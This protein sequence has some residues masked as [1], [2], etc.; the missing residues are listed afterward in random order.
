[1]ALNLV[2]GT[3]LLPLR[4][5]QHFGGSE[6]AWG[7]LYKESRCCFGISSRNDCFLSAFVETSAGRK[8]P[9][10]WLYKES[11]C[12]FGI[13]S[14]NW[15]ASSPPSSRLRQVGSGLG[16]GFTKKADAVLV[17]EI[18]DLEFGIWNLEFGIW[19]LGFGIWN[20]GFHPGTGLLPPRLRQDFGR[21]EAALGRASQRKPMLFWYLRFGIWNLGFGIWNLGF[22]I[23]DLGFGIWDLGFLP[24][25]GLLPPRLRQDFGRSEA[26]LGVA[27]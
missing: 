14:R 22:G 7:W 3:R 4:L 9:W 6:V 26:A 13:S 18:W 21:S 16:K 12:C 1:M 19:N 24:G 20:L 5:R 8:R 11:R 15:I 2:A 25:T 10:G 27:L 23:W 17:F